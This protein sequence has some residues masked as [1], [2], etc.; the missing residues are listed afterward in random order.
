CKPLRSRHGSSLSKKRSLRETRGG[1]AGLEPGL[2]SVSSPHVWL[3]GRL[4]SDL[5]RNPD[6]EGWLHY[7]ARVRRGE[8]SLEGLS[9]APLTSEESLL[10]R[11][12][13]GEH[14]DYEQ[15]P[16]EEEVVEAH[17]CSFVVD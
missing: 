6:A 1:S 7:L 16:V 10:H 13:P 5:L 9:T 14:V 8:M 17:G 11:G 3:V 2:F 12:K 4:S 15:R